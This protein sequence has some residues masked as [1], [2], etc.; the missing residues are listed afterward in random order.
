MFDDISSGQLLTLIDVPKELQ[1]E[2]NELEKLFTVDTNKLK[3]IA[4]RFQEEL[5]EG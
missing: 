3:Q 4:I 5:E 1:D 2:L